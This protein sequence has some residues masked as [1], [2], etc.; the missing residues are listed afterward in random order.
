MQ[1][2]VQQGQ[3]IPRRGEIG[4]D[5]AQIEA[6]ES[7]GYVMSGSRH[8]RM[9]AVRIRKEGQVM[10]AEE[11]RAHLLQR[12]EAWVEKDGAIQSHFKELLEERVELAKR[13]EEEERQ[14][15]ER[16]GR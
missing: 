4:M 5:V 3:R 15:G 6:L 2:F 8:A 16:E 9:N 11:K 7:A 10:D 14:R 12:R 1:A 13:R